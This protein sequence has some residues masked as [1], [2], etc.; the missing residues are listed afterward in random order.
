M[1]LAVANPT[2]HLHS[3]K[4]HADRSLDCNRMVGNISYIG[5]RFL[6]SR[7]KIQAIRFSRPASVFA[8]KYARV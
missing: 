8:S 3:H 6:W 1:I 2:P 7:S 4:W 5:F